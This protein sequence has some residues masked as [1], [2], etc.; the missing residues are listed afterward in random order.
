M[1][2]T[3]FLRT[4]AFR[5]ALVQ[6]FLLAVLITA[7]LGIVWLSV[8]A[9]AEKQLLSEVKT[10]LVSLLDAASNGTIGRQIAQRIAV[11]PVGPDY[12][13]LT[14]S[15]GRRLVGNLDYHATREGWQSAPLRDAQG[16]DDSDADS[17][18][19]YARHLADG[20]WLVVGR[21]NRNVV[22]LGESLTER[23]IEVGIAVL[24]LL[25]VV[26]GLGSWT[27]LRR[28]DALGELAEQ[29]L[30]SEQQLV[31]SSS[32]RSDEFDRLADRLNRL[33]GRVRALVDGIRQVSSDIA[34]DLRTPLTRVRQRLEASLEAGHGEA[35]LRHEVEQSLV[36]IDELL[37]TFRA[38]LRIASVEA[39]HPQSG[40]EE[41]DLSAV[42]AAI[43]E[44][45]CAVAEDRGQHLSV[46]IEPGQRLH[47]DGA[48]LTQ[49]LSNLL[50][51]ALNHTP[52]G[53]PISLQLCFSE[54]G[55]VG[56]IADSGP[57]IAPED[58]EKVLRRFVRLDSSRS[59]PGWGL[60][61]ALVV[62]IAELHRID[63]KLGDAGPGLLVELFFPRRQA[64]RPQANRLEHRSP[65]SGLV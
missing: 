48:L 43:A 4:A 32:G 60:G 36:D 35:R 56:R 49:M 29:A 31:I 33:L 27:Y 50:E 38:L 5:L 9:D 20:R 62:A 14:D 47:G 22:E 3:S 18:H 39:R 21:D 11:A 52:V 51:N 58:R 46:T 42:F 65:V 59:A 23:F 28:I 30:E 53:T 7:L 34:H 19:L 25:L 13:L 6:A 12:Y 45:Y 55:L 57:G 37:A 26:G 41:L 2:R 54:N 61:L 1:S 64:A 15:Q 40:F 24:V 8:K 63:L 16:E 17:V 10:E 44:T